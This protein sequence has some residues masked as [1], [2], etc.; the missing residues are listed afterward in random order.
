MIDD[1][2]TGSLHAGRRTL[3]RIAH[4]SAAADEVI[5]GSPLSRMYLRGVEELRASLSQSADGRIPGEYLG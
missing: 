2:S 3:H 5:A 4:G 1:S